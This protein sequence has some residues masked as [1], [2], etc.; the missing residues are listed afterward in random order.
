[1]KTNVRMAAVI[2]GI[3]LTT[4]ALAACSSS[5]PADTAAS[6]I[7]AASSAAAAGEEAGSPDMVA[8]CDQMVADGLSPD[9]ATALAE[10]NGYVAR[11]GTIDGAPQAVTMDFRTDRFTFDVE[12]GV[13]V[14]CTYG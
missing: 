9:D 14:A 3:V 10:E 13:V 6:A 7:D 8:L 2:A 12:N 1:M 5:E 11:V 4:G